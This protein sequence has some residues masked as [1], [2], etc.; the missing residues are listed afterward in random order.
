MCSLLNAMYSLKT[1]LTYETHKW[2][3]KFGPMRSPTIPGAP[4][5]FDRVAYY[6]ASYTRRNNGKGML[7]SVD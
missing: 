4:S 2:A 6:A 1:P 5:R 7:D 3:C